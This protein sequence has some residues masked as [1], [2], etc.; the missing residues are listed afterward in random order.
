MKMHRVWAPQAVQVHVQGTQEWAQ[1]KAI[2]FQ[3]HGI[4]SKVFIYFECLQEGGN[5]SAEEQG[6]AWSME[7]R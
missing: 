6:R 5:A 2:N 4:T 1:G 7:G 3:L